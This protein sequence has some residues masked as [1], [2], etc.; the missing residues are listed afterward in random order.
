MELFSTDILMAEHHA[1]HLEPEQPT[2]LGAWRVRE[3]ASTPRHIQRACRS[4]VRWRPIARSAEP[5]VARLPGNVDRRNTTA[6]ACSRSSGV[7]T[8]TESGATNRP[9][10]WSRRISKRFR[11]RT[12][13]QNCRGVGVRLGAGQRGQPNSA[14]ILS[15]LFLSRS[16]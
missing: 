16:A 15:A 8:G 14:M 13:E 2:H 7:G 10:T 4:F 9:T 12:E 3:L 1:S 11:D 5:R 6:W